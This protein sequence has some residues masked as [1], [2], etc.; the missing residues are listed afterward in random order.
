[1]R[2]S[3]HRITIVGLVVTLT[4]TA[5]ES[6]TADQPKLGVFGQ[7][8][9]IPQE[10]RYGQINN[11]YR[12]SSVA[13]RSHAARMGLERGDIIVLVENMWFQDKTGF[14]AALCQAKPTTQIGIINVRTGRFKWC[15]CELNHNRAAHRNDPIPDSLG[16]ANFQS[17]PPMPL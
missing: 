7:I 11:G 10:F 16:F 5:A 8:V 3:R 17:I 9:S 2:N 14:R 6:A 15:R 13:R 4:F 1:M 12:I